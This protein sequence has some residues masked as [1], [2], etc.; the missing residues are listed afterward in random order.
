MAFSGVHVAFGYAGVRGVLTTVGPSASSI[1]R[2][3]SSENVT[4]AGKSTAVA[5]T[6]ANTFFGEPVA[7]VTAAAD[8]FVAFGA[9]PD[10][11]TGARD[12][13]P[14]GETR[15]YVV[16]AGDKMAWVAA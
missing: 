4:A 7:R 9:A 16:K 1:F 13:I 14:A 15:D 5:P 8:S 11:S 3:V 10:A 2:I 6:D 12:F